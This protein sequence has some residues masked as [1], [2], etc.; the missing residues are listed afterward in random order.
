[1]IGQC[2]NKSQRS[3]CFLAKAM[4]KSHGIANVT[5]NSSEKNS[6]M[7]DVLSRTG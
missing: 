7:V 1:M 3:I 6:F 5:W 2:K 4:F